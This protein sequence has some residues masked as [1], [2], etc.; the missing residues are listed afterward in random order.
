VFLQLNDLNELMAI[1]IFDTKISGH[2]MVVAFFKTFPDLTRLHREIT[3][4]SSN[5][6]TQIPIPHHAL[7]V[8]QVEGYTPVPDNWWQEYD[9]GRSLFMFEVEHPTRQLCGKIVTNEAFDKF[10]LFCIAA[11]DPTRAL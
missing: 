7:A 11:G 10:I 4:N 1:M 6:P 9:T 8:P 5:P 3:V 2:A